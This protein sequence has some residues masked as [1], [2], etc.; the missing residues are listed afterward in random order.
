MGPNQSGR[1][2]LEKACW[3]RLSIRVAGLALQGH[4]EG[5]NLVF[6]VD[7]HSRNRDSTKNM[8]L[9]WSGVDWERD[10][11]FRFSS[12]DGHPRPSGKQGRIVDA[13]GVEDNL[14]RLEQLGLR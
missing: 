3:V 6:A 8:I 4:P 14:A 10:L 13:W 12:F 5:L 2:W 7:D 1:A 9:V 11:G